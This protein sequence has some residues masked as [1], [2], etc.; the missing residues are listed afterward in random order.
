MNVRIML[1]VVAWLWLP[2]A[3]AQVVSVQVDGSDAIFL[4]GR[5]DVLPIPHPSQPWSVLGRHAGATPEEIQETLPSFIGVAAGDVIRVADPAIGSI[6]FFNGFDNRFG[7]GGNTAGT[8]NLTGLGGISGYQ[9][10][11]GPL[12]G[13]FL[14]NAIPSNSALRP[15]TVNFL[16]PG[17][18]N[19][20]T[21]FPLL[22]QVFYIGDGLTSGGVLQEFVAPAGAT[23]LFFGIPDGFNFGGAPGAYDDNDGFYRIS[24]G[25]NAIPV[26]PEP[27]TYALLLAG[28][29]LLGFAMR[30]RSAKHA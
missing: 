10:P 21:F 14:D 27:Q 5:T 9:G 22:R 28:L 29:G 6:D 30:R 15:P 8:S 11:Q 25:I 3:A 13:V 12:V 23:R 2:A 17:A 4:A 7:P 24:V 18:T 16:L 20:D 19:F 26:I 1:A